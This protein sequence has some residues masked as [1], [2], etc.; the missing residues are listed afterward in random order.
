LRL[1]A[2]WPAAA[3]LGAAAWLGASFGAEDPEA[4][5]W[6]SPL[7]IRRLRRYHLR[8]HHPRPRR[9]RLRHLRRLRRLTTTAAFLPS[10]EPEEI[11][12]RRHRLRHHLRQPGPDLDDYSRGDWIRI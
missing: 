12:R 9:L 4:W 1:P 2:I 10:L 7:D 8:L 11:R 5:G 3:V 6:E